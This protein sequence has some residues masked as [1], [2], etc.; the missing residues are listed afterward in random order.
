M[1]Y[2]VTPN[3]PVLFDSEQ[4]GG[5]RVEKDLDNMGKKG[6]E[7]TCLWLIEKEPA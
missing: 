2:D 3:L 1:F 7:D 6:R 4:E 5:M